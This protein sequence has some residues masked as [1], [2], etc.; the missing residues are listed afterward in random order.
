MMNNDKMIKYCNVLYTVAV[1]CLTSL[2]SLSGVNTLLHK[3]RPHNYHN[4]TLHYY[5]IL[6]N[7][8]YTETSG[9]SVAEADIT[10][11]IITS[12]LSI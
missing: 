6:Y 1:M 2:T 9:H 7:Y 5:Y 3:L 10:S 8:H 12:V 4:T 11:M